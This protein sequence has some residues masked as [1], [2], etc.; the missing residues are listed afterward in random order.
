RG[1]SRNVRLNFLSTK[2]QVVMA[3]VYEVT[4]EG[5]KQRLTEPEYQAQFERA[6]KALITKLTLIR[7][8]AAFNRT[9]HKKWMKEVHG[10]GISVGAISD[11]LGGVVPPPDSIWTHMDAPIASGLR[12]AAEGKLE[13]AARQ[14]TLANQ[15]L[16]EVK[17][18][19]NE[20]LQATIGG[21]QQAQSALEVTRDV[22]FAIAISAAAVVAAPV[23]AGAAGTALAGTGLTGAGLT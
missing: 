13:V 4:L 8:E 5:K 10:S 19:W 2:P 6:R 15:T 12:L 9:E 20:Y 1:N 7:D 21:A 17:H 22:S 3:K 18:E 23:I 16:R 14:L 11:I